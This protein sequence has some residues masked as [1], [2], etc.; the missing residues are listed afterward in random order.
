M[1][2]PEYSTSDDRVPTA[3]ATPAELENRTPLDAIRVW[4]RARTKQQQQKLLAAAVVAAALVLTA[5]LVFALSDEPD[6]VSLSALPGRR[7]DPPA[8][9]TKQLLAQMTPQEKSLLLR[10]AGESVVELALAIAGLRVPHPCGD[11]PLVADNPDSCLIGQ[12]CGNA[13][14]K[15]PTLRMNDGPQ[16]FR[17]PPPT[18]HGT[19]LTT[20]VCAVGLVAGLG[21]CCCWS[22]LLGRSCCAAARIQ[23]QRQQRG[24]IQTTSDSDEQTATSTTAP[25]GPT[26]GALLRQ[27]CW[28]AGAALATEKTRITICVLFALSV[29]LMASGLGGIT[30]NVAPTGATTAFPASLTVAASFDREIT[31]LW[32]R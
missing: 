2:V 12:V 8:M 18:T 1:V 26:V 21:G 9:R 29:L 6:L 19:E 16:G 28:P 17:V 11:C 23:K 4:I 25:D 14:L 5:V 24:Q 27:S 15:I 7:S 10:G 30:V 32:G 13:R 31:E 3:M 20:L 22:V